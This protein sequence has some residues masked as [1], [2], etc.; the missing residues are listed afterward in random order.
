MRHFAFLSDAERQRL[1]HRE[2]EHVAPDDDPQL[3][4]VALGATLYSPASR[5]TLADD[6]AR[7]AAHGVTSMVVCLEDAVAD[8]ELAAA[9]R[10]AV[11]QLRRFAASG[12]PAPLLFVRVRTPGQIPMI[13]EGLGEDAGVLTGF[14]LPKFTDVTGPDFLDEVVAAGA[15]RG[16]R[17]LCMPVLESREIIHAETRRDT[18]IATRQLLDKYREHVLAV[19]IGATDLSAAYGLR[20][21]RD[22]TVYDV[23][24]IADVIASVV[25]VFGRVDGGGDGS[26]DGGGYVVTGP[27][28]EY[29]SAT[30]RWFKPQLRET[31]FR[32]HDERRLRAEL[33]ANDLD[34]LI[35]E[36]ALD[37]ANGLVGKTVIHPSHVAAVNALSVVTHEEWSDAVDILGTAAGGGVASSAYRNKM[38]ESKPHTA[39][40]RRTVLRARAFGVARETVSF[41]DLLGASLHR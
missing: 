38:N 18:L 35:R 29:F 20:R 31:P 22:L 40:A 25:N 33:I 1:F 27:V 4:A 37:R 7:R 10:N 39:W 23:R 3:V 15:A 8:G 26:V 14:V 19:R 13:V 21:A 24:I 17:L 28:W 34:G 2:P 11:A 9:E 12:E 32:E 5:P 41:V 36:V 6:I 30:E 16:R